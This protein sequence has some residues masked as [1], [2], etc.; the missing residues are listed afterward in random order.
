MLLSVLL[1]ADV[2]LICCKKKR[3]LAAY[4][5]LDY[6]E[7]RSTHGPCMEKPDGQLKLWIASGVNAAKCVQ[8]SITCIAHT[9]PSKVVF[10]QSPNQGHWYES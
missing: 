1:F 8:S 9:P 10:I 4:V 7:R 5:H 3:H 2:R 6:A